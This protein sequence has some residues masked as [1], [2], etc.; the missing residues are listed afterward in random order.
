MTQRGSSAHVALLLLAAL[1]PALPFLSRALHIDEVY[2]VEVAEGVRL[3]PADP[4]GGAAGLEDVDHLVFRRFGTQPNT[5]ESM[6]H[7]PLVPYALALLLGV[8]GGVSEGLLHLAFL[9]F[10]L[11][12]YG[13]MLV[14]A[15]RF[16]SAPTLAFSFLVASPVTLISSFALATDMAMTGLLL[17]A[18]ASFVRGADDDEAAPQAV[19]GALAGLAFLARYAAVVWWPLAVLYVWLHRRRWRALW[20]AGLGFGLVLAPWVV[21]NLWHHGEVHLISAT[22]HYLRFYEG[23]SFTGLSL[24]RRGVSDLAALGGLHLALAAWVLLSRGRRGAFVALPAAALAGWLC[25]ANPLRIHELDLHSTRERLALGLFVA[26]GLT[27]P[28]LAVLG[29]GRASPLPSGDG[30]QRERDRVFLSLWLI[31]SLLATL[32]LLP[33]GAARYLLP[34]LPPLILLLFAGAGQP[35]GPRRSRRWAVALLIAGLALGLG[36]AEADRRYANAYRDFAA[37]VP[38]GYPGRRV[39]FVGEWGFRFYM[40]RGGARSLTS[41]D[42]SP[43]VG[44][45]VVRP[46]NAGMHEVSPPLRERLARRAEYVTGDGWPLRLQSFAARAGYYSSGWGLLPFALSRAPLESFEVFE[47]V[48][49]GK[50]PRGEAPADGAR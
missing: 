10:A 43:E 23:E 6:S 36:L 12:A 47:V 31:G 48:S 26:L 2:F 46:R 42:D 44:D 7:P 13:S 19:A 38:E 49:P 33:F 18:L 9:G 41:F 40:H 37:F 34:S 20:R 29:T 39:F 27:L 16:T 4:F 15:R 32:L 17:A 28:S 11:L 24:A 3:H 50:A 21:E 5:F 14:L 8:S 1:L 35:A 22:R 45:I 30:H 25:L